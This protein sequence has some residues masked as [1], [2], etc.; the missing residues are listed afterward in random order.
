M[1][2]IRPILPSAA[3][4]TRPAPLGLRRATP[5]ANATAA[6]GARRCA[7]TLI[8]LLVVVAIIGVLIALLLPALSRAREQ[9]KQVYCKN[10]LR[11]IWTG[12]LT[13]TVEYK[14]RLPLMENV[15][16]ANAV[17]GTG[18]QA[19]PFD[20]RYPT[21]IGVVLSRYITEKVWA[22]PAAVAGY[23]QDAGGAWKFTYQFG[24]TGH[25]IGAVQPYDSHADGVGGRGDLTNYWPWD[26]R[27]L[28][29]LDGRRY[30]RFGLN[31]SEKGRWTVRFPII[32]DMTSDEA[33]APQVGGFVYPH[34]GVLD[35]RKDLQNARASFE[36]QS[37]SASSASLSGRY[38]LHADGDRVDIY[39]TRNW[40]THL[41]GY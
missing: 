15:N 4:T 3:P 20:A 28:R 13:Y 33:A 11:G 34:R 8:E 21:T 35:R 18:P 10:N 40:Q 36:Q 9:A 1:L 41:S 32:W 30:T 23:P 24:T 29:L 39:L 19:D 5:L 16:E 37:N 22:C 2:S 6:A 26:G 31:E 27:P 38:E 17:A 12:I 14:D 7:F 25:G